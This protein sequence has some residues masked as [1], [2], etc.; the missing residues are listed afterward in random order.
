MKVVLVAGGA[1]YIGSHTCKALHAA[2]YRPVVF[3]NLSA[4]HEWAVQWGPLCVGDIQD[5]AALDEAITRYR[6]VAI[7]HFAADAL[8]GESVS[9]PAKYYR[10]NTLGSFNL[11]E[12]ARRHGV[13][14]IVFSSTCASYGIPATVPIPEDHP[15]TPINAY[16]ASK[17]AV[18]HMLAHYTPAYGLT[19]VALRY[20]NAAGASPDGDLGEEHDPETHLIPLAIGAALGTRP[21]LKIFGT[22]YDTPDGTAIRDYI[23]VCDLAGAH[24]A[25][26]GYLLAGRESTRINL[27][28]GKGLSVREVIGLVEKALGTPV[29][30]EEAPRRAGDPPALV[31]DARRA[32]E[33][34]HWHPVM[35]A[36]DQI[37][38]SACRWHADRL[39]E[40]HAVKAI[41]GGR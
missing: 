4:G 29:P 5:S 41:A 20:F 32:A 18:E 13:K 26:L 8:V 1:G 23:H 38:A 12:A 28:T 19:S 17:L 2:G 14:H 15:Q 11:L 30:R 6:P 24:V 37:I 27:G 22:D 25:A 10:N 3:D 35:S 9:D 31:A 39:A 21:P 36:P 40:R 7:I 33:I 16:G 34:L